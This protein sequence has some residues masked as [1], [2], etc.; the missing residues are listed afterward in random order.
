MVELAGRGTPGRLGTRSESDRGGGGRGDL[1][2]NRD[3]ER[4]S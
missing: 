1:D 4:G 3:P 2:R